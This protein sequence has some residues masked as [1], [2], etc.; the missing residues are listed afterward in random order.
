MSILLDETVRAIWFI[1]VTPTQDFLQGVNEPKPGEY[2]MQ[3]RFRYY[4]SKD[5]WD[6]H[7]KKSWYRVVSTEGTLDEFIAKCGE[8]ANKLGDAS[9]AKRREQFF[10]LIRGGQSLELFMETFR[11]QGFV[12]SRTEPIGEH[13]G[14]PP[15][16]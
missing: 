11:N 10:E 12:H 1:Q 3:C 2:E 7:D 9:G 5:P 13:R 4:V 15:K 14:E 6:E 8:V 16:V